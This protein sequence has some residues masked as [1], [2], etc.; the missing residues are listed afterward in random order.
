MFGQQIEAK[1]A[2]CITAT[3]GTQSLREWRA[4]NSRMQRILAGCTRIWD[5]RYIHFFVFDQIQTIHWD[6]GVSW[7]GDGK[8]LR[9][10]KRP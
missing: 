2:P 9:C 3:D 8:Q 6:N 1:V 10:Y 7:L 4:A 5:E